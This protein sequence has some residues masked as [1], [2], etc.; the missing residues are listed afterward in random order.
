M[1]IVAPA[2][3]SATEE[4]P[5][6]ERIDL[7]KANTAG[8]DTRGDTALVVGD[9]SGPDVDAAVTDSDAGGDAALAC[10]DTVVTGGEVTVGDNATAVTASGDTANLIAKTDGAMTTEHDVSYY[11]RLMI[12]ETERL[13]IECGKWDAIVSST[14]N[15]SDDG[16]SWPQVL[17]LILLK[18]I[19]PSIHPSLAHSYFLFPSKLSFAL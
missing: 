4:N 8:S 3:N 14:D 6:K 17:L 2:T 1:K 7:V 13:T 5:D 11:R 16:G 12:S 9:A 18:C 19:S 10:G 15:L